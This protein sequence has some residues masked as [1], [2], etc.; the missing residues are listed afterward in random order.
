MD[1]QYRKIIHTIRKYADQTASICLFA[2]AIICK[3]PRALGKPVVKPREE[4]EKDL[5]NRSDQKP[6]MALIARVIA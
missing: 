5:N 6:A 4:I 3:I 2:E 1:K